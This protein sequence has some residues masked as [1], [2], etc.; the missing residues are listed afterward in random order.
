M[1]LLLL[2]L[3]MAKQV[4]F[5]IAYILNCITFLP[6]FIHNNI[7]LRQKSAQYYI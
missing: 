2:L 1:F 4:V 3:L 7:M 6:Q 5:E